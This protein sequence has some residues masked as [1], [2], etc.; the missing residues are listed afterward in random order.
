MTPP[1]LPPQ[2]RKRLPDWII[3]SMAFLSFGVLFALGYHTGA[4]RTRY[5]FMPDLVQLAQGQLQT[6]KQLN[7][8][9]DYAPVYTKAAI[10]KPIH[11][12]MTGPT[13]RTITHN[14]SPDYLT[15]THIG[16]TPFGATLIVAGT[17]GRDVDRAALATLIIRETLDGIT[18]NNDP[19]QCAPEILIVFLASPSETQT[20]TQ[21]LQSGTLPPAQTTA[22]Y[23]AHATTL[24]HT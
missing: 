12:I 4:T 16:C 2:P 21:L 9:R 10:L 8:E 3:V 15:F 1:P 13:P 5:E 20:A 24:Q 14:E 23:I 7:F 11:D 19:P 17:T 22:H 6:S 18:Y